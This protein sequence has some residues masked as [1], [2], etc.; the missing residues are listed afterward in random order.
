MYLANAY[1]NSA[2]SAGA[3]TAIALV[4][5]G[6][7]AFWLVM[8]FLAGTSS[9]KDARQAGGRL[10]IVAKAAEDERSEAGPA[11]AGRQGAAA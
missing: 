9:Q 10:T 7:L 2:I 6:T 1:P 8:M 5:V 4:A 3:M 11:P